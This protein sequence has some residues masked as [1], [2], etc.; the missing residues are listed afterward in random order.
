MLGQPGDM[1][2]TKPAK[3]A[4]D[5]KQNDQREDYVRALTKRGGDGGLTVEPH[6]IQDSSMLSVLAWSNALLV[7]PPHDPAHKAGDLVQVIDL[8]ELPGGY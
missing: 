6:K 3:L 4:I 5:V 2:V 8:A 7:R 1:P